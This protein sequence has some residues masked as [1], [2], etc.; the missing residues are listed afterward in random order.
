LQIA[1]GGVDDEFSIEVVM[2]LDTPPSADELREIL[3]KLEDDPCP[4]RPPRTLG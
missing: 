1:E 3:A 2:Y 4:S